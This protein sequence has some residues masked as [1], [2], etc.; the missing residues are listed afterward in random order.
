MADNVNQCDISSPAAEASHSKLQAHSESRTPFPG[1]VPW[2][3]WHLQC[4]QIFA[5]WQA[6]IKV[7]FRAQVYRQQVSEDSLSGAKIGAVTLDLR[8]S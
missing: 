2:H 1:I 8:T 4:L 6:N 7:P 5:L 3:F